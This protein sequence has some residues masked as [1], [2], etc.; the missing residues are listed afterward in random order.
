MWAISCCG[1]GFVGALIVAAAGFLVV[2]APQ[3]GAIR[4][5]DVPEETIIVLPA[6]LF[7]V[8]AKPAA[9]SVAA[10]PQFAGT[11]N[12]VEGK[13]PDR[14]A[15]FGE[16][17]SVASGD[18][19]ADP[20]ASFQPA[21]TG[22]QVGGQIETAHREFHESS[23]A[24]PSPAADPVRT[25]KLLDGPEPVDVPVPV[26]PPVADKSPAPES[27]HREKTAVH[28][29]MSRGSQSS[30]DVV[31]TPLGRYQ[32]VIN[33]TVERE[34][35]SAC[36]RHKDFITSGLLT[37]RFLV[38]V[39]G[40]V[41][42]VEFVGDIQAGEVQKGFTLDSIRNARLPGMPREIRGDYRTQPLE[43][44]FSFYF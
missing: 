26:V 28:G 36:V 17:D 3:S 34:W 42:H 14:P 8:A 31:D 35:Q 44:V 24:L 37:A 40:K 22:K 21:Q 6:E 19:E 4:Q 27:P 15:Y 18:A 43:L 33:R 25:G 2:F 32:A 10:K 38:T 29:S 30:I 13:R 1:A 9:P 23:N 39:E 12:P 7:E 5:T 20:S 11:V 16:R 41:T